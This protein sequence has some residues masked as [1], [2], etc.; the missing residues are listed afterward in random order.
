MEKLQPTNIKM[1]YPHRIM[2]S[3]VLEDLDIKKEVLKRP[4]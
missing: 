3:I 2:G 4:L 1:N